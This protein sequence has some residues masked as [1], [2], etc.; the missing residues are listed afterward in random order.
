MIGLLRLLLII[1]FFCTISLQA[2][3]ETSWITKKDDTK[4][5]VVKKTETK[6][7]KNDWIKKKKKEKVKKNK[8]KFNE[9]IKESKSWIT[10]KS[11]EKIKDIK[12]NLKKYKN[13]KDLPKADFYFAATI[14]P[15]DNEEPIYGYGYIRSDKESKTFKFNKKNIFSKSDGIAFL[16]DGV[17]TCVVD[18]QVAEFLGD[19]MGKVVVRCGNRINIAG[20]FIQKDGIGKSLEGE[21]KDGNTV[22]FEFYSSK[23]KA[24]AKLDNYKNAETLITRSLP[25]P[26]SNKNIKLEPHGKYYALLIGNS[27]YTNWDNLVS[28]V[29]DIQKIKKVLDKSYKFE[30]I[31]TITNGTK[32]E[33]LKGFQELSAISTTNDYVLIYYSGHGEIKAE[34]AYWVPKDGSKKWG[35]G[36]WININELDIYLREINAH[37]LAVL[38]DSCYVG[39]KF[40]GYNTLDN[41]T[42][43][44]KMGLYGK[45]LEQALNL[46][47]R[48]V[49]AS[50][51]TGVV[52]DTVGDTGHSTFALS[53]LNLIEYTNVPLNLKSIAYNMDFAFRGNS[54]QKPTIYN[55][56]TWQHGGGDF[57]F[58]PKK[59]IK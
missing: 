34:Q 1:I 19:M 51:S 35:N 52:S 54:Q 43:E 41:L 10:K 9:K 37:H 17:T 53:F 6:S 14:L 59:N 49:L 30:K 38:V 12:K 15:K 36:D 5:K 4:K 13:I 22:K 24:I 27:E 57:I 16:D 42:E 58:I 46:R 55:P 50:G 21:T 56:A 25:T 20:K 2:N 31:F 32:K 45:S 33:I 48:T 8:K 26:K 7:K 47:S 23:D 3:S 39:S 28:P 11:K 40:K 18:T 29:N 44:E